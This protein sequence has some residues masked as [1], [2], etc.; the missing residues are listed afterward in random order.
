MTPARGTLHSD[1]WVPLLQAGMAALLIGACALGVALGVRVSP[2][3]WLLSVMAA[4]ALA[5]YLWQIKALRGALFATERWERQGPPAVTTTRYLDRPPITTNK[6]TYTDEELA[7]LDRMKFVD[8]CL[9]HGTAATDTKGKALASGDLTQEYWGILRR[10]LI[11]IGAGKVDGRG[12]LKIDMGR[13]EMLNRLGVPAYL[14]G[15]Q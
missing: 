10:E 8:L 5:L 12:N 14:R 6:P 1:V 7:H 3:G 4:A 15:A 2:W 11:A 13:D 9:E